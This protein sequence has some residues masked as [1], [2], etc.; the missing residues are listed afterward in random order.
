MKRNRMVI[1]LVAAIAILALACDTGNLIAF[2]NPT[3]TPPRTSRPTFTPRPVSSPTPE[4]SPTPQASPTV[5]ATSTATRAPSATTRPVVTKP[6][7][8]PPP[9]PPQFPVTLGNSYSCPQGSEVWEVIARINSSSSRTFVGD[10]VV[11]LL[12]PGG[13]IIKSTV[14]LP[15]DQV[16]AGLWV[17]CR[18]EKWYPHNVKLDAPELRGQGPFIVRVMRGKNDPTPLSADTKV[19]FTQAVRWFVE[20]TVP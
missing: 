7:V 8:P 9:P 4:N 18:A 15:T 2:G 17:N 1:L 16:I 11:G 14:S 20:Y 3:P 6:T 12:T 13:A 5:A 10:Y 19:D